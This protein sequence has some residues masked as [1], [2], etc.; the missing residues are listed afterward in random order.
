MFLAKLK[1]R[2]R[3]AVINGA[4]GDVFY[5]HNAAW[6]QRVVDRSDGAFSR[7]VEVNV[8]KRERYGPEVFFGQQPAIL[9][10]NVD[11]IDAQR[12]HIATKNRGIV[13]GKAAELRVILAPLLSLIGDVLRYEPTE[14]VNADEVPRV[15]GLFHMAL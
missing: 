13:V 12:S 8:K 9:L 15:A 1:V 6:L 11:P 4:I 3:R 2:G 14:C 5:H 7:R 10:N